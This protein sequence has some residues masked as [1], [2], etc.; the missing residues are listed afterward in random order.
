M[1]ELFAWF[2]I[3]II[4]FAVIMYVILDGFDLGIGMLSV[5]VRSDADRD[6]MISA[7]LPFWDGNETWLVFGVAALYGAFPKAFGVVM[8]ALYA[9]M[10]IMVV[11]LLFRGVSFEFRIK[12]GRSKRLWDYAFFGGSLL[13]IMMQGMILGTFI[14][15]FS[16]QHL[17][18]HLSWTKWLNPFGVFCA[19]ALMFGYM[20]L[21]ANFLMSKTHGKVQRMSFRVAGWTQFVVI[22]AAFVASVWSPFLDASIMQRWFDPGNM[23]L[24]SIFPI[25]CALF[26]LLHFRAHKA[27]QEHTPFWMTVGVFVTCYFGFIVSCY[28]YI[29]PRVLDFRDAIAT[30]AALKFMTVGAIIMM[31]VLVFYT[32]YAY[33]VFRGKVTGPLHY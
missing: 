1:I 22:A 8:P 30:M 26:W 20:Q 25:L 11:A 32:V 9:P 33:R 28:P 12:A 21:G 5:F 27:K 10:L 4:A 15:G 24:L 7:I 3:A 2:W 19:V 14:Q 6:V 13:A 17:G 16:L 23:P 18:A 31:P 29:V